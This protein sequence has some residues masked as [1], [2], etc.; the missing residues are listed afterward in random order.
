MDRDELL[1]ESLAEIFISDQTLPVSDH[2]LA[3]LTSVF[4]YPLMMKRR[5][6]RRWRRILIIFVRV[7]L[8][9]LI[10]V[11]IGSRQSLW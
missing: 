5:R 9:A 10:L 3:T 2:Y 4:L 11:L 1:S 6:G 8:P 7:G